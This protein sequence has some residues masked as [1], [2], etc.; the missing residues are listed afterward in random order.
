MEYF[1]NH[2]GYVLVAGLFAALLCALTVFFQ[3]KSEQAN[4]EHGYDPEWDKAQF[5][6]KGCKM[7]GM[8][9]H[10]HSL[11]PADFDSDSCAD[12]VDEKT[13]AELKAEIQNEIRKD[14]QETA[15]ADR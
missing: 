5:A 12:R 4:I 3:A 9:N 7:A 10:M 13:V 1:F 8:C 11:K 2:I 14:C 15:G 6:C